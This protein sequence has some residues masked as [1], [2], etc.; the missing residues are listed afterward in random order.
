MSYHN[1]LGQKGEAL[2]AK[3]LA[4]KG[5]TILAQNFY[6]QRAELDIVAMDDETLVVAEVKTRNSDYFGDPQRFISRRKIG[7]MVKATDAF[8]QQKKLQ[9]EVRFDILAILLNGKQQQITHIKDAFY[10]F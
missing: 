2:A 3:Y 9:C 5:Y 10:H 8:L 7:L 4:S 6:Y 1:Q